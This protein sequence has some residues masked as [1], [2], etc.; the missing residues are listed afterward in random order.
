VLRRRLQSAAILCLLAV[1]L[2]AAGCGGD[3]DSNTSSKSAQESPEGAAR[4]GL[5]VDIGGLQYNVYITRELNLNDV[6]DRA[7]FDG[8]EA[9]PGSALYGVFLRV[10][11]DG[12][13]ARSAAADFKIRDT[14]G[15]EYDPVELPDDNDFAYQPGRLDPKTCLPPDGSVAALGPTGGSLLLFELPN[16]ATENRPL[17]LEIRAPLDVTSG[18]QPER[19]IELDI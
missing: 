9:P 6:E 8:P 14:Q 18:S 16:A 2:V 1:A 11:N 13:E 17:E 12:K 19:A 4:E 7:Y 3:E 5:F 10:C 15:G